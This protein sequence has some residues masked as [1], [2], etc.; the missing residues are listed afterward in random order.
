M[1]ADFHIRI[2]HLKIMDHLILG[3]AA[4]DPVPDPETLVKVGIEPVPMNAWGQVT[5]HLAQRRIDGALLLIPAAMELFRTGSGHRLV[6]L[7]QR[8][9]GVIVKN[10]RAGIKRLRDMRGRTFLISH[11]LSVHHMLVH[12]L[13][14]SAGLKPGPAKDPGADIFIEAMTPAMM[15]E[16][17]AL[18]DQGD[19]AGYCADEPFASLALGQGS[20]ELVCKTDKLWPRH[21][22]CGL[23][24]HHEWVDRHPEA[25]KAMVRRLVRAGEDL[26]GSQDRHRTVAEGF[27]ERLDGLRDPEWLETGALRGEG[28]LVPDLLELERI[29][30]YMV[31]KLKLMEQKIRLSDFVAG[32]FITGAGV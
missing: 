25:V 27:L 7:G 23:V 2:G 18:D 17:L 19:Y 26:E 28:C 30:E 12:N 5:E 15:P 13:L 8:G 32:G 29:Q 16:A 6:M 9:G 21:P 24:L 20:A 31:D 14:T 11:K 3:A 4:A 22:N 1:G 10:S